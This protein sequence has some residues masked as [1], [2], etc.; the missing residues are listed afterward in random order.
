MRRGPSRT[1]SEAQDSKR[2]GED[3]IV[4]YRKKHGL[5]S[6]HE[7]RALRERF[8][9]TQAGLAHLLRFGA[10][11]VSRWESGRNVQTAAMDLLLRLIRDLPGSIVELR[12][13]VMVVTAYRG[14]EDEAE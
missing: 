14:D 12:A 7:I 10:N 9:L 3:A 6:A 1:I 13:N 4:L 11:T 8:H 5:L 2:F